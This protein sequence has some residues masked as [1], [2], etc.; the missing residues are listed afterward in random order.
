MGNHAD[1]RQRF[2]ALI[3]ALDLRPVDSHWVMNTILTIPDDVDVRAM[4]F[5]GA[6]ERLERQVGPHARQRFEDYIEHIGG[7]PSYFSAYPLTHTVLLNAAQAQLYAPDLPVPQ[8]IEDTIGRWV[9]DLD[10]NPLF[11]IL[12]R[13]L[14]GTGVG[15]YDML[16]QQARGLS[17][18]VAFGRMY[19]D[20]ISSTHV[21]ATF[22]DF[23]P[24]FYRH[25]LPVMFRFL[26]SQLFNIHNVVDYDVDEYG[27]IIIEIRW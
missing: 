6:A 7:L 9:N 15:I 10:G 24:A 22:E 3:D 12:R 21:R 23:Y 2:K 11:T 27:A 18:W 13:S 17:N 19:V 4:I 5:A 20:R 1:R 8:G 25:V 16:S 14:E 26:C